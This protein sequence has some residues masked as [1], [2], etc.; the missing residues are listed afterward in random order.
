MAT[1]DSLAER[2]FPLFEHTHDAATT[3]LVVAWGAVLGGVASWVVADFGVRFP[4]F[5]VAT[6]GVGYL[7]YGRRTRRGVLAGGFYMLAALVALAPVVSE[8]HVL[9]VAGMPGVGSPWRHLLSVADL[10]FVVVFLVVAAVPALAGFLVE[11]WGAVR[12]RLGR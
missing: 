3:A 4:A 5:A 7:L 6:L 9:T 11:N 2:L 8:L 12:A 10:L 1:R